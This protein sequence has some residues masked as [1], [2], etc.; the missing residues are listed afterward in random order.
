MD[1]RI[2]F[3]IRLKDG[4]SMASLCREFGISRKTSYKSWTFGPK[5]FSRVVLH[6]ANEPEAVVDFFD[7]DGLTGQA[8]A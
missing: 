5:G 4:E 6:E 1:E 3:L 7:A 8:G 2:R